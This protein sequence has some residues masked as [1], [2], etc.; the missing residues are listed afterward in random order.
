MTLRKLLF[1]LLDGISR[2]ACFIRNILDN[3]LLRMA[4]T[5][6]VTKSLE[7]KT[8]IRHLP[9]GEAV[10]GSGQMAERCR[11]G[12]ILAL[13]GPILIDLLYLCKVNPYECSWIK[14]SIDY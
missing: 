11:K 10:P 14:I 9:I 2:R 8:A 13:Q 1:H 7:D 3:G 5:V 4:R 6:I 12:I